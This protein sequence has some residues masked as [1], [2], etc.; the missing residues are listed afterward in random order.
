MKPVSRGLGEDSAGC[1]LPSDM[2]AIETEGGA[3]APMQ[4]VA[5]ALHEECLCF[6][7]V[8]SAEEPWPA[9]A[10]SSC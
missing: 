1:P 9:M 4:Q 7:V 8:S 3:M 6:A 10:A 2:L 5:H